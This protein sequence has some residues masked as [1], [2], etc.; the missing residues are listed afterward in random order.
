MAQTRYVNYN[1][2]LTSFEQ[3]QALSPYNQPGIVCGFDTMEIVSGKNLK[4]KHDLSG[5]LLSNVDNTALSERLGVVKAKNGTLV[6]EDA[7]ITVSVDYNPEATQRV[8]L[9]IM[10]HSWINSAGGATATYSIIK[11]ST[12]GEA[13]N[14]SNPITQV[15]IGKITVPAGAT[16]HLNTV[17][18]R[19]NP[20]IGGLIPFLANNIGDAKPWP[21]IEFFNDFNKMT[22]FGV[23]FISGTP[24]NKPVPSSDN[25]ILIV[26]KNGTDVTQLAIVPVTGKVYCR[27]YST[28]WGPWVNLNNP[29]ITTDIKNLED[30]IGTR[31]YTEQNYVI[32]GQTITL[33]LDALDIALNATDTSIANFNTELN[34]LN[35]AKAAKTITVTGNGGLQGGGDLS[36]NRTLSIAAGGVTRNMMASGV[37]PNPS[38][39]GDSGKVAKA[40]EELIDTVTDLPGCRIGFWAVIKIDSPSTAVGVVSY[41][42]DG[43]VGNIQRMVDYDQNDE[44]STVEISMFCPLPNGQKGKFAIHHY[45]GSGATIS[46]EIMAYV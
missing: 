12:T 37:L 39:L 6:Q 16:D 44:H 27:G 32:N 14:V 8:D 7:P 36:A 33:S 19:N 38:I 20:T 40:A 10:T 34:N 30:A 22:D 46:V 18:M 23:F 3:N 11:G 1:K 31:T 4:F 35:T 24:S 9:L 21:T 43:V 28:S 45:V 17:W 26:F 25:Y 41:R 42:I 13:P 29:D 2:A 5:A 15:A